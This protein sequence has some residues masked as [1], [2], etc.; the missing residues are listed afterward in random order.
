[1]IIVTEKKQTTLSEGTER[2]LLQD[3]V[4]IVGRKTTCQAEWTSK[5]GH[6]EVVADPPAFCGF[7][8]GYFYLTVAQGIL[9]VNF[10]VGSIM[11]I[12]REHY[13]DGAPDEYFILI[14]DGSKI[15]LALL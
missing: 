2:V 11:S 9:S 15:S 5:S 12:T 7:Y 14:R 4:K 3:F 6:T 13:D 1:M 10:H 8:S